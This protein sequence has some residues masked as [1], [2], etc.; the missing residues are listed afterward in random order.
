MDIAFQPN[1]RPGSPIDA[2]LHKTAVCETRRFIL[3]AIKPRHQVSAAFL[4]SPFAR[5]NH[6]ASG[7]NGNAKLMARS[8]RFSSAALQIS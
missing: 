7:I 3:E 6:A 2:P 4:S 8:I 1:T 5:S